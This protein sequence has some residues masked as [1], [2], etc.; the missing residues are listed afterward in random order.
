MI[1]VG[2]QGNSNNYRLFNQ[3]THKITVAASARLIEDEAY[4]SSQK[5]VGDENEQHLFVRLEDK[6]SEDTS[7]Q[8]IEETDT[9]G[10]NINNNE[11]EHNTN[12]YEEGTRTRGGSHPKSK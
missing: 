4:Y 6:D 1:F 11:E 8:E 5:S 12:N 7:N 2:Y 10:D 9:V 3:K